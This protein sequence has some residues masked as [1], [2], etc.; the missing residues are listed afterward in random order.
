MKIEPEELQ[1][2]R[3]LHGGKE[4]LLRQMGYIET[5]KHELFR[6]YKGIEHELSAFEKS[7]AK[8]Y[9]KNARID[10]NT[11]EVVSSK[12]PEEPKLIGLKKE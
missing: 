2:L 11:G 3:R 6:G 1:T 7:L 8:R 12:T 10:M 9:G 5:Q 4:D